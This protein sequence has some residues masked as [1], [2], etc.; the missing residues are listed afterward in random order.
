M[1]GRTCEV[2]RC[3]TCG[4]MVEVLATGGGTL[5]CCGKPMMLLTENSTDAAQE[6]HV[7]VVEAVEG[8]C[9]V[10]IG[11]V[12]HP[13]QDNH[14]I[15]WIELMADGQVLRRVLNPGDAPEATFCVQATEV[16][17]R[18]YCNLHGLWR[19]EG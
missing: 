13:M 8:G 14:Y 10:T 6:K 4:K 1:A 5:V 11:A 17:A 18:A 7:P 15:A 12:P 9:K 2:Y 19:G 16:A 3:D